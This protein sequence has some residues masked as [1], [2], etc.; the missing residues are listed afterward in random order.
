MIKKDAAKTTWRQTRT[1]LTQPVWTAG[2][3]V[4][5]KRTD[6]GGGGV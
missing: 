3:V 4:A 6:G 2:G 5:V 1:G